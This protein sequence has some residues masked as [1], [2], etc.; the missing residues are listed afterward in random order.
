MVSKKAL[1]NSILQDPRATDFV[2]NPY[3]RYSQWHSL[4]APVFWKDY[5][6]WCLLNFDA[7]SGT[8]RDRRFAR[9][10]PAGHELAPPP[11]HLQEFAKA[12]RYSLL[13]MEPPAHTQLRKL[14]NKA[15]VSRQIDAMEPFI[16]QIAHSSID[17]FEG[18]GAVEL[19]EHY[20]TPLPLR[21]IT[22]VLGIPE[23]AGPQLLAWSHAMVKVYTMTQS[24]E[25]EITANTAAAEF[26]AFLEDMIASKRRNPDDGLL[27]H[28]ITARDETQSISDDEI[29]CVSILLLN[30]GH[31]ATVHQLGNMTA[32]LLTHYAGE[33]RALLLDA[34][35]DEVTAD[36]IVAESLRFA[37]PLHLFT[38]YA[39]EDLT[40]GGDVHIAKGD[41][42]GLLLAAANR[43]PKK[44]SEANTFMPERPDSAHLSLGAGL[45]YCIG[46]LLSKME[47][48]IATQVLFQRLPELM[49]AD[50]PQFQ[51]TYHFHG[52][53]SL[54]VKWSLL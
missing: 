33:R 53:Q 12:E 37:A 1:K 10:P 42:I 45:H 47:L 2:A 54:H 18:T 30:A 19:L 16:K 28:M 6:F 48:R 9:L 21:V 20:A 29:I 17:H 14:V 51:D 15:F 52:L 39:Q 38:R 40:L 32:T 44:F 13:A 27:S 24:F 31:E 50:E 4:D 25:D 23:E 35:K 26:Y 22:R 46:A 43:C 7:V 3:L 34:L 36:A 41:Q 8:L 5:G 11:P 49:L